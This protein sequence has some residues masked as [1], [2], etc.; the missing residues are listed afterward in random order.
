MEV[1][2]SNFEE[3]NK[4]IKPAL[5][6]NKPVFNNLNSIRAEKIHYLIFK[7]TKNRFGL[8]IGER[9]GEWLC[10]FSAPF[11]TF[12]NIKSKWDFYQLEESIKA[13]DEF[14][15]GKKVKAVFGLPPEF[16]SQKIVCTMQNSLF[17]LGYSVDSFDVNF[18]LNLSRVY[19]DDYAEI[20]PYNG[21][22]NLKI[23]LNSGLSLMHCES[24]E[25]KKR[26]YKLIQ[27]NRESRGYPLNMSCEQVMKTIQLV[28]HDMFIVS[29]GSDEIAAALVYH[30]SDKIAQVIYWGDI[31]GYGDLKPIN[32]LSYNLIQYY[33]SRGFDYLDIGIST[34]HS[35]LNFGLADFKISI[36]C[37]TS[38]KL[39]FSKDYS[40]V[41]KSVDRN[42]GA[43][44]GTF[45]HNISYLR[46][47]G[48]YRLKQ[49]NKHKY[50]KYLCQ[51]KDFDIVRYHESVE[52][53]AA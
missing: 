35:V 22:K 31:P 42:S 53:L 43:A 26:A 7:D 50:R 4:L 25:E 30:V 3:Y 10:P 29:N 36:G 9:N 37:D 1:I 33:G 27:I 21:K 52:Y 47:R 12:V 28:D 38:M 48:G 32:F 24:E 6:Y 14:M 19:V 45:M 51:V 23:A 20:I 18:Q 15:Q 16:F 11:G 2:E 8:T 13:F 44:E 5:F 17:N 41:D 40:I 49:Y 39:T 46:N 34:D